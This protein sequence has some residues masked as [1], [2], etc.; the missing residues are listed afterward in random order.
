[1]ENTTRG[2]DRLRRNSAITCGSV[3]TGTPKSLVCDTAAS[4]PRLPTVSS[5]HTGSAANGLV[6]LASRHSVIVCLS[7]DNDGTNTSVRWAANF[8]VMNHAV[9]VLPVPQAMIS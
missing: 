9:N 4:S 3:V 7:S 5:L 8:S 1:M 2:P 6:G